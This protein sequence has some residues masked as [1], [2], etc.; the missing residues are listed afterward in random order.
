MVST[1]S[2][3]LLAAALASLLR[4][5]DATSIEV[6][7]FT[8]DVPDAKV[9]SRRNPAFGGP[10]AREMVT[11]VVVEDPT[12]PRAEANAAA[13]NGSTNSTRRKLEVTS[14]DVQKL[15]GYFQTPMEKNFNTIKQK[16]GSGGINPSPWPSSYW[17]TYLDSINYR[18]Q[19]DASPAEKY[20]RAFGYNVN[21]FMNTVSSVNGIDSQADSSRT[22]T[23]NSQCSRFNDGSACAK[24]EGRSSGYCVPTWYGI[25][26]AWAPAA[27][28][29]AEPRCPV[30][31]NGVTFQ[32]FDIKALVTAIYDDANVGV[33][34]TGA[35]YNGAGSSRDEYGRFTDAA[36][37]D[38]G[39]G[40][41]HIATT[42]IMGRFGKSFVVDVNADAQ[43]WNQPV[44]SYTIRTSSVMSASAGAQKYFNV[45]R[46]PFNDAA[47]N[48][49]YVELGFRYINEYIQDGP[50][51]SSGIVDSATV[52]KTY[53]YLLEL[54]AQQNIIG[55][56]W[57]Y[58]SQTDHP[59]FLWFATGKPSTNTV[60]GIGLKYS[61]VE[62]LVQQ[63]SACGS[64][65]QTPT[66]SPPSPPIADG[67]CGNEQS[68][69]QPCPDGQ[70]CQPWNPTQ[71]QCRSID[72][73][74]GKQE[75]GMDYY[76]DDLATF[77]VLLPEQCC[78]KCFATPGCTAY[79]FVNYNP[80]G[81]AYCYLKKGTGQRQNKA[82]VVS[83][84]IVGATTPTP[85]P[86]PPPSPAPG[87]CGN[88]NIGPQSC[89]A[90][91]YCQ[92]WNPTSYECRSIDAK[93]GKQE[94]GVDFYGDD[95]STHQLLLPEQCCDKCYATAGC[96][97]YTFVNYNSDGKAYCYLKKGTGQRTK[98]VGA[99]S[100]AISS[101]NPGTCSTPVWGMCG[102]AAA[103]A[104]CCSSG[105][106]CQPWNPTQ[107]QCI[108][109]PAKCSTQFTN[110][111]FYGE[112]LTTVYGIGPGECCEKCAATSGCKAYTYVNDNQPQTACYL[113]KGGGTQR[114][115]ATAVSA[116]VN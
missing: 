65:P 53:Y 79:T 90:G 27:I 32:V 24:R 1:P 39:P 104:T 59:D 69:P 84:S 94:V 86:T 82:G 15:E 18:W 10:P 31:R 72:A 103:G 3:L 76:G 58:G 11:P 14:L 57:L 96:K 100:A 16:Y 101:P 62:S 78:D 110:V 40:F 26:H 47:V 98:K 116:F 97:A 36:E 80:D 102:S 41:F 43:V 70:Y 71:Y 87:S 88:D 52:D 83:A 17:P 44:R 74:C 30:T 105:Q 13:A 46:Y 92:P 29:E 75:V 115:H 42:N 61:E 85:T 23:S 95:I 108:N 5:S 64:D 51:V 37:R 21:N 63:S 25:C 6:L 22:C 56:E 4:A 66:P 54:D 28:L 60:T 109:T 73:K 9:L 106:Y 113:K 112:D 7:P 48:V 91:Q 111:D 67:S 19:N 55:G 20:A 8:P 68:G 2:A 49:A 107:Y 33:V 12:I 89:P 38:L 50:L 93:C 45:A 34:F 77:Q 81:K 99:V 114:Y 35:R